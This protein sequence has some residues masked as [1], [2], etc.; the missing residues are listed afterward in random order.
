MRFV[1]ANAILRQYG[2][3][4]DQRQGMKNS[5]RFTCGFKY[6]RLPRATGLKK[7]MKWKTHKTPLK[8]TE[9]EDH[10]T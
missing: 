5:F 1:E 4:S 6:H 8:P 9:K 3:I 2:R 10:M 7:E